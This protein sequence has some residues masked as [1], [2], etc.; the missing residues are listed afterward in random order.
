MQSL[1]PKIVITAITILVFISPVGLDWSPLVSAISLK[2]AWGVISVSILFVLWI[3]SFSNK[4]TIF[5]KKSNL[6]Y[7]ILSF[8]AWCFISLFWV[9]SVY[10]AIVMLAQFVSYGLVFFLIL[11]IYKNL[12]DAENLLKIIVASLVVVSVI[13]ILQHY[14]VDNYF[15]QSIFVQ[16][17][18]PSSTF[19]N[20]NLASHF[21]V[22]VLPI[23]VIFF[24][25]SKDKKNIGLYFISIIVSFWYLYL[26]QARQAHLAVLVELFAFLLFV[27]IDYIHNKD[28]SFVS[29]T[30]LKKIK[31]LPIFLVIVS[32]FL[33][34]L[35]KNYEFN[36]NKVQ[37]LNY[38][39]SLNAR[40]PAWSNSLE[41]VKDSP[42]IGIGVGQWQV[43]Y[44]VYYDR[45]RKD[46][47]FD[48][49]TRLRK[50]H[51]D[52]LEM[53][54]N[55][56]LVGYIFLFWLTLLVVKRVWLILSSVNNKD[57][58]TVLG[59]ALGLVGFGVILMFSYPVKAYLPVFIVLIYLGLIELSFINNYKK[60]SNYGYK[61][62]KKILI[63]ISI[64]LVLLVVTY[65]LRWVAA[66]HNYHL[67]KKYEKSK[68]FNLAIISGNNA[69]KLNS[70]NARNNIVTGNVYLKSKDPSNAIKQFEQAI[71]LMPFNTLTLLNLAS[72]YR[73]LENVEM[74]YKVLNMILDFD[75]KNVV[76]SAKL[77]RILTEK[78][79]YRE[80][81]TIFRK[82]KDNFE[83]F[84]NRSGFGP[85]HDIVAQVAIFVGDYQYARY[86]YNDALSR[87][88]NA[89]NLMKLAAL[90][91][92]NLKNLDTGVSLYVDAIKLDSNIQRFEKIE[93]YIKGYELVTDI[94]H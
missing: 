43:V 27:V 19:G 32:M 6:Y 29:T 92:F 22:I 40:L 84:K 20:K 33:L 13:G 72:A 79:Q 46:V 89:D 60:L 61:F 12:K 26:I 66:E 59:V 16:A 36:I 7:P 28:Q 21:V 93:N 62:N 91:F 49:K 68:K 64:L 10:P 35:F 57:R 67:A 1:L 73:M 41:M 85:Y 2:T 18:G 63:F 58:L 11:N 90:E 70:L 56:G 48:E 87:E 71:K 86:I 75:S 23:S 55:L 5:V 38:E 77:A 34:S 3:F 42:I 53:F 4:K 25:T 88:K 65:S 76:A 8:I 54:V 14:F 81:T 17:V 30:I 9:K 94:V 82:L 24:L 31:I 45:V 78:K 39:S 47:I 69:T 74:E 37:L 44:P 52:Y 51:N 83:Y 50:L 80:A 15:I